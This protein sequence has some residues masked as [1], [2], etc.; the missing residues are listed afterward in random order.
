VTV[1]NA[2]KPPSPEPA[3]WTRSQGLILAALLILALGLRVVFTYQVQHGPIETLRRLAPGTDMEKH[4]GIALKV[5]DKGWI[6]ESADVSPL[7]PYVVLPFFY[8]LTGVNMSIT[9][10]IQAILDTLTVLLIYLIARRIYGVRA[11]AYAGLA[12]AAYAPFIIYQGQL[13]SESLLSLLIAAFFLALVAGDASPGLKRAIAAGALLGLAVATKPNCLVFAPLAGLLIFHRSSWSLRRALPAVAALAAS[14]VVVLLPFAWRNYRSVGEFHLVRGNSGIMLYM[15]NNPSAIGVYQQPADAAAMEIERR[16][17]GL[18]LSGRDRLYR[19][20]ALEFIRNNPKHA[21]SLLWRKFILFFGSTEIPNNLSVKFVRQTTF[22]KPNAFVTFGLVLPFA[23]AGFLISRKFRG[24]WFLAGQALI[25]SAS[26]I[27]FVVGR[28]R[29]AIVPLVMPAAG[30]AASEL[31]LAVKKLDFPRTAYIACAIAAFAV[32]VNW[33]DLSAFVNMRAHPGGFAD[34]RGATAVVHDDSDYGTPFTVGLYNPRGIVAKTLIVRDLPEPDTLSV[35]VQMQ[36]FRAGTL[37][38]TLND[39]VGR[40]RQAPHQARWVRVSFPPQA[41]KPGANVIFVS[42]DEA[43]LAA[44]YADDVYHFGRSMYTPDG[45]EYRSDHFDRTSYLTQPALH[46]GGR[47]FKVR[48]ELSYGVPPESGES[49][50]PQGSPAG[51]RAS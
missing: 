50:P 30:F 7:Y 17:E 28:Y 43:L 36:T 31:M 15:G 3:R 6:D 39:A 38:V 4:H 2:A 23:A 19:E 20:A 33:L 5:L 40:V 22:L 48:L 9:L 1:E 49:A 37:I 13:L 11:A 46:I 12:A 42:G 14:A 25:Y 16:A 8:R 21:L 44:V 10:V 24:S 47:E 41:L 34:K 35:L 27:V 29:L 45:I 18:S 32:L 51:P 26:I